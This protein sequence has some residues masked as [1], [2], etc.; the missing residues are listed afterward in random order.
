MGVRS[1]IHIPKD[2]LFTV[3]AGHYDD[4]TLRG[5]YRANVEITTDF[6]ERFLKTLTV[7]GK[8]QLLLGNQV[9]QPYSFLNSSSDHD[10]EAYA[11]FQG[12]IPALLQQKLITEIIVS[13]SLHI[14]D[15]CGIDIT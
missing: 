13:H 3:F 14:G 8:A 6:L 4:R 1:G 12:F 5:I 15:F 10:D 9:F 11:N 7:Y 2:A